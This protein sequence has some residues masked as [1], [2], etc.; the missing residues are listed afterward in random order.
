MRTIPGVSPPKLEIARKSIFTGMSTERAKAVRKKTDPFSTPTSFNSRPWNFALISA[1][2]SRIRKV[3]CSSVNRMRSMGMLKDEILQ[4]L[5]VEDLNI[6]V[7]IDCAQ[8]FYLT[9]LLR[10][11]RLLHSGQFDIQINFRQIKIRRERL[12][13]LAVF[14]PL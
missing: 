10:Y 2:T 9:I 3:T 13:H 11:Q 14:V 5:L 7:G 8:Q 12:N 6:D 4:I 1:A